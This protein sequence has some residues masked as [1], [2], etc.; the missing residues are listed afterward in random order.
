M[1]TETE[2]ATEVIWTNR[3]TGQSVSRTFDN[4]DDADM[5][6]ENYRPF[7]RTRV[8]IREVPQAAPAA[9]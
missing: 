2:T 3:V 6:A 7:A 1:D 4:P 9:S 8:S 5:A